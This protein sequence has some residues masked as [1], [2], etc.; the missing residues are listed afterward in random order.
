MKKSV[1]VIAVALLTCVMMLTS[2]DMVFDLFEDETGT[3]NNVII[4]GNLDAALYYQRVGESE[5]RMAGGDTNFFGDINWEP[6]LA[7]GTNFRV[8]NNGALALKY[9]LILSYDGDF[10]AAKDFEVYILNNNVIFTGENIVIDK[11]S[12]FYVGTLAEVSGSAMSSGTLTPEDTAR[13]CIIIRLSPEAMGD[14]SDFKPTVQLMAT[15]VD[16][17]GDSFGNDY[18]KDAGFDNQYDA[19]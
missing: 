9:N 15:Q 16:T 2:C 12:E 1:L 4:S 5:Y 10:E 11:N 6:A 19:E 8:V 17:E 7:V 13:L 3:G 14:Y 18:D